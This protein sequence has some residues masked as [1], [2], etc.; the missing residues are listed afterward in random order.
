MNPNVPEFGFIQEKE[1]LL[2]NSSKHTENEIIELDSNMRFSNDGNPL[3]RFLEHIEY[4]PQLKTELTKRLQG[5]RLI[6]LGCG[7]EGGLGLIYGAS[8][9]LKNNSDEYLPY[10]IKLAR[11][12]KIKSYTGVDNSPGFARYAGQI[13]NDSD[14]MNEYSWV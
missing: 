13:E 10:L 1:E 6:D 12:A 11:E 4:R 5:Q 3:S 7:E 8:Q 2:N 9:L 14:Y